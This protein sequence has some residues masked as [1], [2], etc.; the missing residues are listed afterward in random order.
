[1][2][3]VAWL[4][5]VAMALGATGCRKRAEPCVV[6]GVTVEESTGEFRLQD[7]GIEREDLRKI[8]I[9][10]FARTPGFEV[11]TGEPRKGAPR[12]RGLVSLVDARVAPKGPGAQVEVLLR[13]D[14]V[15]ADD[16]DP[17]SE[18]V[19]SSEQVAPGEPLAASIR[20]AVQSGARRAASALALALE[21]ARKPDADVIRDLEA[22]DPRLRE[23]AV[24]VLADRKNPAAVPGLVARL[25]DPDPDVADRAVGA[26]AQIGDPRAVGP[27]IELSRRREG[28]FVAQMVRAV[29][30]IGGPEAEAYLDTLATGHPDPFVSEAARE[31][32]RDARRRRASGQAGTRAGSGAR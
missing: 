11:P 15:P 4:L 21:E 1:M 22:S 20:R 17:V 13:M 2:R 12:C 10:A 29:G 9:E 25:Q 26:L 28:P 6:T 3:T 8:A 19:R 30:D 5:A 24:G 32:L 7:A 14:A 23:L 18:T 31:A 16:S 27:I